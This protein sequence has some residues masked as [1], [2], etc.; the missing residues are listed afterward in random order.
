MRTE[1]PQGQE[2]STVAPGVPLITQT[3]TRKVLYIGDQGP[4]AVSGGK[5]TTFSLE[6][7]IWPL[8]I[9]MQAWASY[10]AP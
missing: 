3:S 10:F 6:T 5:S 7:W 4:T 9:L 2:L 8:A 1:D